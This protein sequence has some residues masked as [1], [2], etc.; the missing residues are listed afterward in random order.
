[1]LTGQLLAASAQTWPQRRTRSRNTENWEG[2]PARSP[3]KFKFC[4]QTKC[5]LAIDCSYNATNNNIKDNP[6]TTVAK[7]HALLVKNEDFCC[8]QNYPMIWYREKSTKYMIFKAFST[9]ILCIN[10]MNPMTLSMR[11]HTC[12][13]KHHLPS[14]DRKTTQ[15]SVW[16]DDHFASYIGIVYLQILTHFIMIC[17]VQNTSIIV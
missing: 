15:F 11:K 6:N 9:R 12:S 13:G 4:G 1:M 16:F 5:S 17:R 3:Q 7:A 8:G 10:H 2:F 14:T